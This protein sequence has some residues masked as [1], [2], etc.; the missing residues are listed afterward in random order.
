MQR[1]TNG[2]PNDGEFTPNSMALIA[3]DTRTWPLDLGDEV[4]SCFLK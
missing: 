4:L 1:Q 2:G 3:M